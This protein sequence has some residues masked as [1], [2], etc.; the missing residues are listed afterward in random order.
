M[1]EFVFE[2]SITAVVR[3]KARQKLMPRQA[4]TSSAIGAPSVAEISLANQASFIKGKNASIT[5]VD[6][7]IDS[8]SI[9][10]HEEA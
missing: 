8:N 3:V 10:P 4:V 6:F 1:G 2:V 5:D 9:K 7:S